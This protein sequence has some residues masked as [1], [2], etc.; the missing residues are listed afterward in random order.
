MTNTSNP[1]NDDKDAATMARPTMLLAS[2]PVVSSA[3]LPLEEADA[4]ADAGGVVWWAHFS[5]LGRSVRRSWVREYDSAM[6]TTA[7]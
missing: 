2:L 7:T 1:A 3:L 5:N 4:E 6:A